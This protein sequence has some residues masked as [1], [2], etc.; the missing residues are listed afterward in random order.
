[1][2]NGT[3]ARDESSQ[4]I[5]NMMQP[6]GTT[7]KLTSSGSSVA[8]N[9]FTN[10]TNVRIVADAACHYAIG[11]APTATT[12]SVYLPANAAEPITIK[13]GNKIAV[14]AASVNFYVTEY[15]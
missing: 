2:A 10:T 3:Q 14:I 1:M 13:A 7:Q 9:A 12:S 4:V 15:N 8:S 11:T 6:G 5:P